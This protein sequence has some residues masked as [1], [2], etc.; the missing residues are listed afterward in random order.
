MNRSIFIDKA[1]TTLSW[2]VLQSGCNKCN[3]L[4]CKNVDVDLI[5]NNRILYAPLQ[6]AILS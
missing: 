2:S 5:F 4:T 3:E 1:T 6:Q